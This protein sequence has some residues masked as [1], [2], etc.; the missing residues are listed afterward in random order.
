MIGVDE[1]GI[2]AASVSMGILLGASGKPDYKKVNLVFDRPFFYTI[3]DTES[4]TIYFMGAVAY[5]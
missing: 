3:E 2:E 5:L 1:D 4:G